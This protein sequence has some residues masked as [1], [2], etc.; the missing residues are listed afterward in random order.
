M[1]GVAVPL[2]EG[3]AVSVG[4]PVA[5]LP[6][7]TLM[8]VG[9]ALQVAEAVGENV[10]V[11]VGV[12]LELAVAVGEDVAETD[13]ETETVPVAEALGEAVAEAVGEPLGE[14]VAVSVGES[15]TVLSGG[16]LV[17]VGLM[18][19]L[20]SAV[21]DGVGVAD[22]VSEDEAEGVAVIVEVLVR[23]PK[24]VGVTVPVQGVPPMTEIPITVAFW[25]LELKAMSMCPATGLTPL[26]TRSR[27]T[28]LPPHQV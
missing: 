24:I 14:D 19:P 18:V 27:A 25:L 20:G 28:F 4:E 16:T 3:V 22:G 15:V 11:S 5:V 9:L 21:A 8:K 26:T 17:K 1:P 23:V 2:G 6:A 12:P 10:A 13:G 7:G